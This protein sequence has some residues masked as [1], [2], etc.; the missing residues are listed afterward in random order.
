[1]DEDVAVAVLTVALVAIGVILATVVMNRF[2]ELLLLVDG[3]REPGTR[4]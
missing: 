4:G 3:P 2:G 1:M